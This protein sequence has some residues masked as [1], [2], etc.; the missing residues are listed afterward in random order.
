MPGHI[1]SRTA[2][3]LLPSIVPVYIATFELQ[4]TMAS[5]SVPVIVTLPELISN[6]VKVNVPPPYAV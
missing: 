3:L 5:E 4:T 6:W 2:I 1:V